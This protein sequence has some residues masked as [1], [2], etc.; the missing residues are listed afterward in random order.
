MAAP[1]GYVALDLVGFTDKGEYSADS[2]Y[3]M[4]DLVHKQ[5]NV[6]KCKVDETCGVEPEEGDT[7]DIFVRGASTMEGC[8]VIDT[9]GLKKEAGEVLV[10][11]ELI[12]AISEKVINS[13]VEKMMMTGVQL[14]SADHIPTAALVYAM[15]QIIEQ[16]QEQIT[17]LYTDG[18]NK[19]FVG[20]LNQSSD[21]DSLQDGCHF[22]NTWAGTGGNNYPEAKGIG[23]LLQFSDNLRKAQFIF[24][25]NGTN[26]RRIYQ[27]EVWEAW[28]ES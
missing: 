12:D 18:F 23:I 3:M 7:W 6:W 16:Q 17:Q 4:N 5:N 28:D 11:Q 13:F 24:Y 22:I 10:A 21:F 14:N 2:T 27:S 20:H 26:P 15:Q 19:R 8:T 1:E 9:H 25:T